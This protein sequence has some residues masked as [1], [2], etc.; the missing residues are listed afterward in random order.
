MNIDRLA[1]WGCLLL[2]GL[3]MA[4]EGAPRQAPLLGFVAP[5]GEVTIRRTDTD[6]V[7]ATVRP[8]LFEATWQYRGVGVSGAAAGGGKTEGVIR[9]GGGK[10]PVRVRGE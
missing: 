8:G 4:A 7:V 3:A 1:A 6:A 5:S 2:A 10:S 9:A